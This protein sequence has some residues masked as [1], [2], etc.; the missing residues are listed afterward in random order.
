MIF[1][2]NLGL[3]RLPIIP[4][5][6]RSE[7]LNAC[8]HIRFRFPQDSGLVSNPFLK[9]SEH[10]PCIW[11]ILPYLS[12]VVFST[13]YTQHSTLNRNCVPSP[14]RCLLSLPLRSR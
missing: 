5:S 4:P 6:A 10:R 14:G 8:H 1:I 2:I 13:L 3:M 9:A 7:V 12:T 11:P